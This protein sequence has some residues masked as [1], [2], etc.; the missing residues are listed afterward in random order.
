LE[1]LR[2]LLIRLSEHWDSYWVFDW[3]PE[4]PWTNNGTEQVIGKMKMR[5]RTVR[6]YKSW[7]GMQAVLM[8]S[9]SG[10]TW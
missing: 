8:L 10:V 4:V 2:Y 5:S 7:S 3:Q 1:L 9:G 6:G